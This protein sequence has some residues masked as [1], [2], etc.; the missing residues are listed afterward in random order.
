MQVIQQVCLPPTL[1]FTSTGAMELTRAGDPLL[2]W[3]RW[4]HLRKWR[5]S[6]FGGQ[7]GIRRCHSPCNVQENLRLHG[8]RQR[9]LHVF[10]M[11]LLHVDLRL[12]TP[13]AST[14]ESWASTPPLS[15]G[16]AGYVR[17]TSDSTD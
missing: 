14:I 16:A 6:Y 4:M 3:R 12:L 5:R 17:C 9:L 15:S 8:L 7:A 2:L 13:K 10:W 11:Y 1:A